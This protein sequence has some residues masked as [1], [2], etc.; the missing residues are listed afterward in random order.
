MNAFWVTASGRPKAEPRRLLSDR[1]S[2]PCLRRHWPQPIV[3][4]TIIHQRLYRH[5]PDGA[6][7]HVHT[8]AA[9]S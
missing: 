2:D 6:V 9:I 7:Y 1:H 5:D 3:C 4:E 8:H